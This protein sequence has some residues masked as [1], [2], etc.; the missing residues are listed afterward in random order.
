MAPVHDTHAAQ[1]QLSPTL[2][3]NIADDGGIH[4]DANATDMSARVM[5]DMSVI[6]VMPQQHAATSVHRKVQAQP[7][8]QPQTASDASGSSSQAHAYDSK[9]YNGSMHSISAVPAFPN[10]V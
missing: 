1:V 10:Y 8:V 4:R 5:P 3:V 6:L 2:Y 9:T 7:K